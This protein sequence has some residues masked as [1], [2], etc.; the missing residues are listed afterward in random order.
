MGPVCCNMGPVPARDRSRVNHRVRIEEKHARESELDIRSD[1]IGLCE[2]LEN[3]LAG[4]NLTTIENIH[5]V[6]MT[7]FIP[8]L[9]ISLINFST[10]TSEEY[11]T[12]LYKLDRSGKFDVVKARSIIMKPIVTNVLSEHAAVV[13]YRRMLQQ[14]TR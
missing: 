7:A 13:C 1:L 4:G 9:P 11:L 12:R 5:D 14:Q 3:A 2:R 8:E 6:N 10:C